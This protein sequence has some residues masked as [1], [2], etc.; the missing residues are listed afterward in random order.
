MI[1][2][3]IFLLFCS[4]A[5]GQVLIDSYRYS[6]YLPHPNAD[7]PNPE[8]FTGDAGSFTSEANT[9]TGQ[10]DP[11]GVNVTSQSDLT[12]GYG[13]YVA[14]AT[15]DSD[16]SLKR[17]RVTVSGTFTTGEIYEV[18]VLERNSDATDNAR[19]RITLG[20]SDGDD[21]SP[22]LAHTDWQ[23]HTFEFTSDG[24]NPRIEVFARGSSTTGQWT[25]YKLSVKLKND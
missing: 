1:R 10:H 23:L 17:D 20:S 4:F 15:A 5:H 7:N 13:Q 3:I 16:G 11:I 14:R 18:Y 24:A 9:I 12:N 2:I 25:E 8:L 21:N 22:H 6:P 19:Y